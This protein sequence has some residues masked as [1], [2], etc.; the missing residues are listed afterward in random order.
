MLFWAKRR[1]QRQRIFYIRAGNVLGGKEGEAVEGGK[2]KLLK[3]GVP[4]RDR[5]ARMLIRDWNI[6]RIPFYTV[7]PATAPKMDA[8]I[9]SSYSTELDLN[10]VFNM[11]SSDVAA[12][13]SNVPVDDC[14]MLESA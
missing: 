9:L 10:T 5:A 7:P 1:W 6:G 14:V 13:S 8:E 11:N 12:G 2:G 4:D 3:G